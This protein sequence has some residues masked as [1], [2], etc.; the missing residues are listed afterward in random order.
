[1]RMDDIYNNLVLIPWKQ[2]MRIVIIT[3]M[4]VGR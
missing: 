3:T 2:E 4:Q 1:M